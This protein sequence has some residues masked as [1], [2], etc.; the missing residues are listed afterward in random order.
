MAWCFVL[1]FV[2]L[3]SSSSFGNS[4]TAAPD[5][6]CGSV[7]DFNECKNALQYTGCVADRGKCSCKD[8]KPFCRCNNYRQGSVDYWYLGTGCEQEWS[9]TTLIL[10][11]TLPG[12]CLA[13]LVGLAVQCVYYWGLCERA[14]KSPEAE[15]ERQSKGPRLST[16]LPARPVAVNP[17]SNPAFDPEPERSHWQH[18]QPW[19]A[20][21]QRPQATHLHPPLPDNRP[22]L[23]PRG[24]LPPVRGQGWPRSYLSHRTQDRT[25]DQVPTQGQFS[26]PQFPSG[27]PPVR[28]DPRE[29]LSDGSDEDTTYE[30]ALPSPGHRAIPRGAVPVLPY[31]SAA[32]PAYPQSDYNTQMQ[33]PR[34]Q[35]RQQ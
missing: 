26:H 2:L 8:H 30:S 13:L 31:R 10:V 35:I 29:N 18:G 21:I 7:E 25:Q 28:R 6:F 4:T 32:T 15:E 20:S 3:L 12:L 22:P 17:Y 24:E 27:A 14:P 19:R 5:V 23:A 11:A 34:P 9:T 16:S 33:V 1:G